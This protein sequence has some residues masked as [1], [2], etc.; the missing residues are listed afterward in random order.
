MGEATADVAVEGVCDAR[1][2]GV[3]E[4]FTENFAR[5]GEIGAAIAVTV[6]GKPVVDLILCI[7][8]PLGQLRAVADVPG[9]PQCRSS[10]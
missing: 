5:Y 7:P 8:Q 9:P 1:F 3:R 6:D 10:G 4:A 2:G